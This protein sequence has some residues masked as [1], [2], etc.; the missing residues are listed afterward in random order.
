M[1]AERELLDFRIILLRHGEAER[2]AARDD[3]RELTPRGRSEALSAAMRIRASGFLPTAIYA[4][5]FV[6][7]RQTAEIVARELHSGVVG[8][9]K[10]VT[11]DDDPR[12]A[13]MALE[14]LLRPGELPM[15][16]THM[17]FIGAL[18]G[19]LVAGHASAGPGFVTAGGVVLA[20]EMLAPGLM[21]IEQHIHP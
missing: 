21:R 8:I 2:H 19:L 16:V 18:T 1:P 10:G 7:A 11:P 12:R 4:S 13:L 15:V 17:P 5:P 14:S 20:G 9:V 3:L 6:R